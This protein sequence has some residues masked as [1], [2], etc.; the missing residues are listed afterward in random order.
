MI[1]SYD[2]II[3]GAPFAT[4]SARLFRA[5]GCTIGYRLLVIV[6]FLL[7]SCATPPTQP[8]PPTLTP[9]LT[10]VPTY[11]PF[12]TRVAFTGTGSEQANT[13]L[14]LSETILQV[15]IATHPAENWP[16]VIAVAA[17]LVA[18]DENRVFVRVF[19]PKAGRWSRAQSLGSG[20]QGLLRTRFRTAQ[21]A[22][23]GD[24][25]VFAVWGIVG[26]PRF[27]VL[28]SVSHDYGETWSTPEP[29]AEQTFGVCD[30]VATPDGRLAV[31]AISAAQQR[32]I[33]IRRN[34]AGRWLLPEL[35]PVPA[36]YG[37]AGTLTLIGEGND[38]RIVV[39]TSGGGESS[40]D[41]SLFLLNR[42]WD[43]QDWATQRWNIPSPDQ[44][45]ADLLT[46]FTIQAL[47]SHTIVLGFA[48]S[49]RSVIYGLSSSD[50]GTS[51]GTLQIIAQT[52]S[53]L[54]PQIALAADS[55]TN[56]T[57]VIWTC[58]G[59]AGFIGS[60][61]THYTSRGNPSYGDWQPPHGQ[62][63]TPLITGAT[64]A[65]DTAS[66]QAPNSSQIWLAWV[67]QVHQVRVRAID[68]ERV[69]R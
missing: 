59:D 4:A 5:C 44:K 9:V 39:A 7:S 35:L 19:N 43:G 10:P 13:M 1:Y 27:G 56:Q 63:G 54:A 21:I 61:S 34:P 20:S 40:P 25:S 49:G 18:N 33:L 31:L 52:A 6:L 24:G 28:A 3:S 57:I 67:E 55:A 48:M 12:P 53:R 29:L 64:A 30:I 60:E 11:A 65:A 68:L 69:T 46:N 22:I 50:A 15:D 47:N 51:W 17:P 42:S 2:N 8:V 14:H 26:N 41:N 62:P 16:A 58:C 66:A 37:S 45:A 38:T 23:T 32:P 36:W